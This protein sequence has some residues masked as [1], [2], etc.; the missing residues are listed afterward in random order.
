LAGS[1]EEKGRGTGRQGDGELQNGEE[2]EGL[3]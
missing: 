2:F 3:V 1:G